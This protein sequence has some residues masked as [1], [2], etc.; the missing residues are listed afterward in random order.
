MQLFISC[1]CKIAPD[2]GKGHNLYYVQGSMKTAI[3]YSLKLGAPH[4]PA[5]NFYAPSSNRSQDR[6]LSSSTPLLV[7]KNPAAIWRNAAAAE[8]PDLS[9]SLENMDSGLD[10]SAWGDSNS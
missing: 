10:R 8:A 6:N 1:H 5:A 3:I 7:A 2:A 4:G 9:T